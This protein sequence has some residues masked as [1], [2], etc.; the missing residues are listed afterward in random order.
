MSLT[1][2]EKLNIAISASKKLIQIEIEKIR[3]IKGAS[4]YK[5]D[6]INSL[7]RVFDF[8]EIEEKGVIEKLYN[9]YENRVENEEN[10]LDEIGYKAEPENVEFRYNDITYCS[11]VYCELVEYVGGD[12]YGIC[13]LYSNDKYP[14]Y[15]LEHDFWFITRKF[16]EELE[17]PTRFI[18]QEYSKF[19][20]TKI[21]YERELYMMH[22]LSCYSWYQKNIDRVSQY[23][24]FKFSDKE[25]LKE[26]LKNITNTNEADL[27]NDSN[28][29]KNSQSQ[30]FL[31]RMMKRM[32]LKNTPENRQAEHF[33]RMTDEYAQILGCYSLYDNENKT[34][35]Y[36]NYVGFEKLIDKSYRHRKDYDTKKEIVESKLVENQISDKISNENLKEFLSFFFELGIS[37]IL[38]ESEDKFTRTGLQN[39]YKDYDGNITY[40]NMTHGKPFLNN[41]IISTSTKSKWYEEYNNDLEQVLDYY[42]IKE[43]LSFENGKPIIRL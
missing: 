22:Q 2:K 40:E 4:S 39:T 42:G 34:F 25:R 29:L 19:S 36:L 32:A 27:E 8:F 41:L 20:T 9:H 35:S 43:Y 21:E 1:S 17:L 28:T 31:D 13:Q 12:I 33:K 11:K 18:N 24:W 38:D 10:L 14:L 30:E 23:D 37:G 5:E 15:K 3:K 16:G 26:K 6:I 7:K